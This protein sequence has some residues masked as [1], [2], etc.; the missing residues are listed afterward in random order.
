MRIFL[1][2]LLFCSTASPCSDLVT[3]EVLNKESQS[4]V[5]LVEYALK[6]KGTSVEHLAKWLESSFDNSPFSSRD[7][8]LLRKLNA[9][10]EKFSSVLSLQKDSIRIKIQKILDEANANQAVKERGRVATEEIFQP[11][12]VQRIPFDGETYIPPRVYQ[13]EEGKTRLTL[14]Y[15]DEKYVSYA[16]PRFGSKSTNLV[17]ITI[18]P[19]MQTEPSVTEDYGFTY[20]AFNGVFTDKNGKLGKV[21]LDRNSYF[22]IA[23]L[24]EEHYVRVRLNSSIEEISNIRAKLYYTVDKHP[25]LFVTLNG[26]RYPSRGSKIQENSIIAIYYNNKLFKVRV[27]Q[28]MEMSLC[29]KS[30]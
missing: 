25:F 2:I 3:G 17:T 8:V 10:L 24:G 29:F 23:N 4:Y 6:H 7:E 9:R 22:S 18:D 26:F 12:I 20:P 30:I 15:G 27:M 14:T 19:T 5:R 21:I 28:Y 1:S 16:N 13:N 11:H